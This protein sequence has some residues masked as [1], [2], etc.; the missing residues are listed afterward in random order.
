MAFP[1]RHNQ[2]TWLQSTVVPIQVQL[3]R[4]QLA[5]VDHVTVKH[6]PHMQEVSKEVAANS[7]PASIP[8]TSKGVR[9]RAISAAKHHP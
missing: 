3:F 4:P 6:F 2:I 7:D 9:S 1:L 8:A 5:L